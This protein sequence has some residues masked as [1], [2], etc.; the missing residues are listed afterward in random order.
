MNFV[1]KGLLWLLAVSVLILGASACGAA[2]ERGLGNLAWI[3]ADRDGEQDEAELGAPEVTVN[4]YTEAG[5]RVATT[6]TNNQG[7]YAF[8]GLESG[9]YYLEFVPNEKYALTAQDATDDQLDSDPDPANGLTAVFQYT[10]GENDLAWDAGVVEVGDGE[11]PTPTPT[12]TATATPTPT[13]TPN[14]A[15]AFL[16]DTNLGSADMVA[17]PE[18]AD[19]GSIDRAGRFTGTSLEPDDSLLDL[20]PFFVRD[21]QGNLYFGVIGLTEGLSVNVSMFQPGDP[22]FQASQQR[23]IDT[24]SADD[25]NRPSFEQGNEI[26]AGDPGI[27]LSPNAFVADLDRILSDLNPEEAHSFWV[28]RLRADAGGHDLVHIQLTKEQ[29]VSLISWFAKGP[30]PGSADLERRYVF[31]RVSTLSGE[32]IV[33]VSSEEAVD[34]LD[35]YLALNPD[36]DLSQELIDFISCISIFFGSN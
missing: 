8:E 24:G 4:L 29:I 27:C 3:D 10:A 9:R 18:F 6:L 14:A 28:Y 22:H 1:G 25:P 2:L 15:S 16:A 30:P 7:Y 34:A 20:L 31:G 19:V 36:S 32:Q 17:F 11:S 23:N 35:A 21:G 33:E 26:Y 13:A 5:A 12:S